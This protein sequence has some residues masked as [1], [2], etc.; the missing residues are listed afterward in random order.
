VVLRRSWVGAL[1]GIAAW[2]ALAAPS[3]SAADR[4]LTGQTLTPGESLS[5]ADGHYEL[6]LR[7]D[8]DLLLYVVDGTVLGR[9]LWQSG[10]EGDTG[11]HA[12][13]E[14]NGNL[15]LLDAAGETLWSANS[16]TGGQC[17]NLTVQDDGNL[18]VYDSAK[19]VW[20]SNTVN[21]VLDPGDELFAGQR[22]FAPGEQYELYMLSDGD[23]DVIGA[24]SSKPLWVTGTY[25]IPGLHA[26]MV[27]DG[28]LAV[29]T[30]ENRDMWYSHTGSYKG[31]H[32]ALL[33]NGNLEIISGTKV[34]WSSGSGATRAKG[35]TK[36]PRPAFTA[37]PPPPPPPPPPTT[38]TPSPVV[39]VPK[40]STVPKFPKLRLKITIKW[41][42]NRGVTHLY[43]IRIFHMPRRATITV[44]CA[45]KR[46]CP[47]HR[48][49]ADARHLKRLTKALNGHAYRAGDKLLIT[50]SEKGFKP[51][52]VAVRIRYGAKPKLSLLRY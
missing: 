38:T 39:L 2:G 28:N 12:V 45:G 41:T 43:R 37:C 19:A 14:S 51:E 8:G 42:W 9:V 49:Q 36:F 17:A 26:I 15:V 44:R 24:S 1:A 27:S 3:A 47:R 31:A 11:D 52:R 6:L 33:S 48:P 10:T 50:V 22:I 25:N 7:S 23:L 35:P 40:S 21:T 4:L 20:A 32:A 16:D 30:S 13:L 5:S 46:G 34:V 29:R 18:V